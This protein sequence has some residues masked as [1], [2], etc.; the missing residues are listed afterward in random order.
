MAISSQIHS[1]AT[2]LLGNRALAGWVVVTA[3]EDKNVFL[4]LQ[5]D[6][7]YAV[8]CGFHIRHSCFWFIRKAYKVNYANS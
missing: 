4:C 5:S 2:L 1:P 8:V 6:P 7:N 3:K